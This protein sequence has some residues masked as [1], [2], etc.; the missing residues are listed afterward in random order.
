MTLFEYNNDIPAATNNPSVDQPDMQENTNAID[1]LLDVDHISFNENEG[2]TH[3]QVRM[4]NQSAPGLL[5]TNGVLYADN[6]VAIDSNSWP[7][8]QNSSGSELILGPSQNAS[9]GYIYIGALLFQWGKVASPGTTGTVTFPTAFKAATVPFT[10]QL[11]L[12]RNSDSQTVN[13]DSAVPPTNTQFKFRNSS[14]GSDA[15]YWFAIGKRP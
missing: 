6:P 5:G 1:N 2:G 12:Q 8:W 15:L 14:G 3:R 11:Q 13:V 9:P 10:I 7:F 4:K